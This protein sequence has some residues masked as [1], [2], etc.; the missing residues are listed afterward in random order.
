MRAVRQQHQPRVAG[1]VEP[2][3]RSSAS[4]RYKQ[5]ILLIVALDS[6]ATPVLKLWDLR[7]STSCPVCELSGHSKGVLDL[8]WNGDDSSFVVSTGR[9]NKVLL[10]DLPSRTV[11]GDLAGCEEKTEVPRDAADFF[12]TATHAASATRKTSVMWN[13]FNPA[14]VA[15]AASDGL[16]VLYNVEGVTSPRSERMH[17]RYHATHG[18]ENRFHGKVLSVGDLVRGDDVKEEIGRFERSM[19]E[20]DLKGYCE[21]MTGVCEDKEEQE[22]WAFM[23]V[24]V[25]E[26]SHAVHV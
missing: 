22:L 2:R 12:T 25:G 16:V 1:G 8:V 5:P 19:G 6:D 17:V 10:W 20:G 4:D 26:D 7:S 11:L 13:P 23:K 21:H 24:G 15:T 3:G 18:F 14:V 9:D